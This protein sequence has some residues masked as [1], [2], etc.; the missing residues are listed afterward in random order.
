MYRCT[1]CIQS[2]DVVTGAPT[3]GPRRA[4]RG[5]F[6]LRACLRTEVFRYRPLLLTDRGPAVKLRIGI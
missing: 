5:H 3:S 4:A 6:L 1:V 2:P